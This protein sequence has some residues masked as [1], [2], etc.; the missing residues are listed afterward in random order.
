MFPE[1]ERFAIGI[2]ASQEDNTELACGRAQF[3]IERGQGKCKTLGQFQIGGIIEGELAT[4]GE[5]AIRTYLDTY[6]ADPKPFV[7]S[8]TTDDILASIERFCLRISNSHDTSA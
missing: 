8:R 5:Q 7:W 4:L 6:N 2:S 1:D 3:L